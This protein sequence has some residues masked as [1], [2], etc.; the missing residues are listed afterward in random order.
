MGCSQQYVSRILK[1]TENLSI[2]TITK[3]ESALNLGI[4]EPCFYSR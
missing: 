1:G 3:I 2:E 4:L